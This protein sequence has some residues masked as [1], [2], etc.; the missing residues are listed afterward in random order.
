M[1]SNILIAKE[2][3]IFARRGG[4]GYIKIIMG[5]YTEK[6]LPR[7]AGITL[8]VFAFLA[9]YEPWNLGMREFFRG[10]GLY[11]VEAL[12]LSTP[13]S[14]A[15]AHGAVIQNAFPLFPALA[16]R[17]YELTGLPMETAL[18]LVS[19]FMLAASAVMVYFAAASER[20]YRAG[21]V[22]AA[23]YVSTMLA[24]EKAGDGYPTTMTAFCLLAAQLLFF[25]FGYRRTNW[26]VAWVLSLG[27]MTLGFFA[28]GFLALL[29]FIVP[30]IFFRRPLSVRSKFKKPGFIIGVILLGLPIFLWII[31][32]WN[33]AHDMPFFF[34][35]WGDSGILSYLTDVAMFP[36]EL[37]MRLLPWSLIAWLP[38]CVAL[39]SLD[40]TPIFSRYLRTLTL[41]SLALLWFLPESDSREILYMLGPLSILV[42]IHYELGMRRYG[43]KI[44]RALLLCEWA[45]VGM[46]IGVVVLCFTPYRWLSLF[47]SL[48]QSI[49]FSRVNSYRLLALVA[50][51]LLLTLALVLHRSRATRPV[52]LMLL[53]TSACGGIFYWTVLQP[54]RAQEQDK[55]KMGHMVARALAKEQVPVLYKQQIVGLYG[56]L[57]YSGNRVV[58]LQELEELPYEQPVVYLLSTEFP[59][60]ANRDWS[61]LLAPDY[62]YCGHRL[63]LW[64][65]VLRSR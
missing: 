35:F 37:P 23:M 49:D 56:E 16:G 63:S 4:T 62:T 58:H 61:N 48:G 60:A 59:Q 65:G 46:A 31:N 28:G 6:S 19:I 13:F 47:F 51:C 64:K 40:E 45:V 43:R 12:E 14:V 2:Q 53:I 25:Q 50:V 21:L 55:R 5:I 1:K 38:F 17:I 42:G 7:W 30:M 36:L 26:S 57:F 34:I 41:S 18:R 27:M 10:E 20:S 11:A 54:Y 24:M 22:A 15:T 33:M 44:R 52:W 3:W 9:L 8:L 32:C 39:Q 29:Y